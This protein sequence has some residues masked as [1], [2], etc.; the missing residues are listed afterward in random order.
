M[1]KI[2]IL[3]WYTFE[4]NGSVFV[5]NILLF[6]DYQWEN[7]NDYLPQMILPC[8]FVIIFAKQTVLILVGNVEQDN[9]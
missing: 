7:E 6:Y 8:P 4:R 3:I 1:L 2:F 5:Y 9:A